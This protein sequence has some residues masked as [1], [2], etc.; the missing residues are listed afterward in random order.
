MELDSAD[1]VRSRF[2]RI[3]SSSHSP[4]FTQRQDG[5]GIPSATSRNNESVK[6][7]TINPRHR[8]QI[9]V[10]IALVMLPMSRW[11]MSGSFLSQPC[12]QFRPKWSA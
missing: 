7:G 12:P 1:V 9:V 10:C 2:D 11:F 6:D 4:Q 3:V 5:L 8:L